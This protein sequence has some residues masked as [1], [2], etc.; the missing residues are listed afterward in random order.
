MANPEHLALLQQGAG[1]WNDWVRAHPNVKADLQGADLKGLDL[2]GVLLPG[3]DLRFAFLQEARFHGA[4]LETAT[5][6]NA[7]MRRTDLTGAVL[8]GASLAGANLR[9][10]IL[11]DAQLDRTYLRRIDLSWADLTRTD[12]R[13][14]NLEYARLVDA[15]ID[16]ALFSHCHIYGLSAWNLKGTPEKQE[17]LVITRRPRGKS[18]PDP[19]ITVDDL[20]VAQFIHLLLNHATLRNVLSSVTERG[21]LL[22]GRF[23]DGGLAVL[24]LIAETLRGLGYLPI[25]F[26]FE[27]PDSRDYTETVKTLVG[28]SRFVIVDVSGPSVP[29]EL[30]ATVPH[31]DLP[32][33]PILERGRK[34]YSMLPDLYKYPWFLRPVVQFSDLRDLAGLIPSK[35][36]PRAEKRYKI[37]QKLLREIFPAP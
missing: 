3:A 25:L 19:A 22:L 9:H 14:A 4:N 2:S 16:G 34:G 26:D 7:Y 29:Q 21:V 28:L 20:A 31:F 17:N 12:F 15:T 37:R 8:R 23:G 32:F 10:G 1:V 33:V 11:V 36:V 27:R 5:I 18:T 24:Q 6:N 30:Y 35:I 13:G